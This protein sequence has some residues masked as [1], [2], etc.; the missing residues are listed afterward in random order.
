MGVDGLIGIFIKMNTPFLPFQAESPI[1]VSGPTGSGKTYW[2]HKLLIYNMFSKPISSIL[3]CYGVYQ[4]YFDEMKTMTHNIEYHEG[5]PSL[6][7]VQ[8]LTD[9]NFN[10][11]I[12]DDLMEHIV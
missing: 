9:D 2:T 12:S 5:L 8:S 10:I 11:I 1:M 3:Y 4:D 7:K 6:E